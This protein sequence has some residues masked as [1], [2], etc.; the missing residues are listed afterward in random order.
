MTN[1]SVISLII[2]SNPEIIS[3]VFSLFFAVFIGLKGYM[4]NV[5]DEDDQ[6]GGEENNEKKSPGPVSETEDK[7]E[8]S[9]GG[10]SEENQE[11]LPAPVP[12]PGVEGNNEDESSGP[13]SDAESEYSDEEDIPIIKITGPKKKGPGDDDDNGRDSNSVP[14]P[15]NPNFLNPKIK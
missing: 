10:G 3:D 5:K 7:K 15:S 6:K 2:I 14:Y 12:N 4:E 8:G 1:N 9:S 13:D 11:G